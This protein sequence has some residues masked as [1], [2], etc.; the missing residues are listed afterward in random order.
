MIRKLGLVVFLLS[1]TII[2]S[3]NDDQNNFTSSVETPLDLNREIFNPKPWDT[4]IIAEIERMSVTDQ[5]YRQTNEDFLRYYSFQRFIDSLN[6]KRL[7]EIMKIYGFPTVTKL[8]KRANTTIILMH[9]PEFY[10]PELA[11]RIETSKDSI[12]PYEYNMLKWHL[13][14]RTG[15]P[16]T[17][18]V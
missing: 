1:L 4:S 7:L 3:C 10:F 5:K 9:A 14:G 12:P 16:D 11:K 2:F 13:N 17:T 6:T 8:K 15:I 18:G